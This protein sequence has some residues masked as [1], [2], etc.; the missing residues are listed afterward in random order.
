MPVSVDE[1]HP[2]LTAITAHRT[3]EEIIG[4]RIRLVKQSNEIILH[5]RLLI[6]VEA[7]LTIHRFELIACFIHNTILA[8]ILPIGKSKL[9]KPLRIRFIRFWRAERTII[10][11]SWQNWINRTDKETRVRKPGS[12]RLVVSASVLHAHLRVSLK[13]LDLLYK[14]RDSRLSVRNVTRRH[15]DN[16]ARFADCDSAFTFRDIDTNSVHDRTL[17]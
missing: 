5:R 14:G 7:K 17:L 13:G 16:I 6:H 15:K 4:S 2:L 11:L 1:I 9:G 12:N 10:I 8:Q 3:R